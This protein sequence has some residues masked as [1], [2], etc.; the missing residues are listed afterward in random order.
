MPKTIKKD[1]KT[2]DSQPKPAANKP[3][4]FTELEAEFAALEE[5]AADPPTTQEEI[6]LK[7]HNKEFRQDCF[8]EAYVAAMG[9]ITAARK[10][11]KVNHKTVWRW[12][13]ED[14]DFA[15]RLHSK[16]VEWEMMLRQKAFQMAMSGDRV[17]IIFLLKFVNPFFDDEFRRRVLLNDMVQSTYER[18]P[19]PNPE[20]LP[21]TIPERFI[22]D[23]DATI[24]AAIEGATV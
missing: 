4:R 12:F 2:Q 1:K 23:V 19:I 3:A 18:Y 24:D 22:K 16:M 6:T 20:F 8:I 17:M 13:H 9:N 21:P 11:V 15:K 10:L 7:Q 14:P 5:F